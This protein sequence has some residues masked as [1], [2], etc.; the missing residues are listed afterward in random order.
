MT[1]PGR[2]GVPGG[3]SPLTRRIRTELLERVREYG[4]RSSPRVTDTAI[5]EAA[6]EEWLDKHEPLQKERGK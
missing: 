6:I 4:E 1:R 2:P 5:I 3:K